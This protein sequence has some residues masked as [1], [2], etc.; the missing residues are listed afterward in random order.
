M[1]RMIDYAR[2]DGAT[3]RGYLAEAAGP[4]PAVVVI[5]EWWGLN[6]QIRGIA[7]HIAEAGFTALAPDLFRGR[8]AATA[9]EGSHLMNELDFA[10]ATHQDIAGAVARLG[11]GGARVGVAGFC[12]GGALTIA[13]AVH[14]RAVAAA[15]CFYGI[16]PRAF[17]DPAR[18]RI[19]FQAH[20]ARRDDWCTPA[21]VDALEADMRAAGAAPEIYRYDAAHAFCNASRAEVYDAACADQAWARTF[22]FFARTL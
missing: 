4:G 12:M 2:P 19:P 1:G 14:L 7:D 3:S 6:A 10:D 11:S 20:F 22:A 9:D 21:V 18:I 15:V 13:A 16:P 17:A 5:Q 8:L